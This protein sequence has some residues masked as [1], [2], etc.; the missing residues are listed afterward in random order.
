MKTFFILE[1]QCHTCWV[2][3]KLPYAYRKT[4]HLRTPLFPSPEKHSSQENISNKSNLIEKCALQSCPLFLKNVLKSS[5]IYLQTK[6]HPYFFSER[7]WNYQKFWVIILLIIFS[8]L[9]P[10]I[11]SVNLYSLFFMVLRNVSST[12][13][14][15]T[16]NKEMRHGYDIES[17]IRDW[18]ESWNSICVPKIAS[19]LDVVM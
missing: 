8:N 19:G 9:A 10:R 6:N 4:S 11:C 18:F 17:V 12:C 15:G 2:T 3:K 13:I 14:Y 16:V 5:D 7:K 1:I